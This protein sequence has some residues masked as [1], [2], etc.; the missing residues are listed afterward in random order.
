MTCR[1]AKYKLR[2]Q[3][4][5]LKI[6]IFEFKAP[7]QYWVKR[8]YY[9]RDTRYLLFIINRRKSGLVLQAKL[10]LFQV[11]AFS[12]LK[13]TRSRQCGEIDAVGYV[14]HIEDQGSHR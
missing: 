3:C 8:C 6:K 14:I 4:Y 11:L 9:F 1:V 10:S 13:E 5:K 12:K 2:S 7:S